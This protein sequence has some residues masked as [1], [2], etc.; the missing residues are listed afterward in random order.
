MMMLI[1][2]LL[3]LTFAGAYFLQ[4]NRSALRCH[5]IVHASRKA[6]FLERAEAVA[7]S[8]HLDDGINLPEFGNN[9]GAM[10]SDAQRDKAEAMVAAA[11]AD[12]AEL[13]CGGRR[14]NRPSISGANRGQ[15][16]A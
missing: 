10:V 4:R 12:G 9:M 16:S 3:N 8:L 14:L 5:V 13:V 2:K 15:L 1:Y 7:K 6:E 11:V